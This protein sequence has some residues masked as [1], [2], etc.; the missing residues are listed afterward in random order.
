MTESSWFSFS[1]SDTTKRDSLSDSAYESSNENPRASFASSMDAEDLQAKIDDL[2]MQLESMRSVNKAMADALEAQT[3]LNTGANIK[4]LEADLESLQH[5]KQAM[6]ELA[7]ALENARASQDEHIKKL[8]AENMN[9]VERVNSLEQ[10]KIALEQLAK[11][12]EPA[13]ASQEAHIKKLEAEN[14]T[15]EERVNSL[16]RDKISME[17]LLK[18]LEGA[19]ASQD[20]HIKKLEGDNMALDK[21]LKSLEQDKLTTEELMKTLENTRA[22]QDEH[23]KSLENNFREQIKN[24]EDDKAYL[25]ELAKC[26]DFEAKTLKSQLND[27]EIRRENNAECSTQTNTVVAAESSTQVEPPSL[28]HSFS[29]CTS[30]GLDGWTQSEV[31]PMIDV[32]TQA[33]PTA[34]DAQTEIQAESS[35]TFREYG[36]QIEMIAEDPVRLIQTG[37]QMDVISV[38]ESHN[39]VL[40]IEMIDSSTGMGLGE[41]ASVEMQTTYEMKDAV[42]EMELIESA[43]IEIQTEYETIDAVTGMEL[44]EI[45]S[46]EIQAKYDETLNP[47]QQE[48]FRDLD[49][50][51]IELYPA[52][53]GEEMLDSETS[54]NREME[55]QNAIA[56]YE[57]RIDELVRGNRSLKQFYDDAFEVWR[58]NELIIQSVEQRL[59]QLILENHLLQSYIANQFAATNEDSIDLDKK[60][61]ENFE[62][63]LN[64]IILENHLLQSFYDENLNSEMLF[65]ENQVQEQRNLI[66]DLDARIKIRDGYLNE[67]Y[68]FL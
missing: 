33:T 53:E 35:S 24:L 60:R 16:E 23:I 21:S 38:E 68:G 19:R 44:V 3:I 27:I 9:L 39:H 63:R 17:D 20:E 8:E 15:M 34:V 49:S 2:E 11:A 18:A 5:N 55:H 31:T 43:T 46:V 42:T 64:Q 22:S 59:D 41:M 13:R 4:K 25:E 67:R 58:G 65:L 62:V 6:E 51:G 54:L 26:S 7:N 28:V 37:T 66:Q 1:F 32:N 12:M 47:V 29:Q 45:A 50:E 52:S 10:D 57:S 40:S 30:T 61:N 36:T 48:I 14:S 56:K